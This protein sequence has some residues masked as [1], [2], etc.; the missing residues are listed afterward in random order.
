V[1]QLVN[2][3]FDTYNSNNCN[4]WVHKEELRLGYGATGSERSALAVQR[5]LYFHNQ[6]YLP[7]IFYFFS[8]KES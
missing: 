6:E 4:T 3:N 7:G 8:T 2:K 1:H 5:I